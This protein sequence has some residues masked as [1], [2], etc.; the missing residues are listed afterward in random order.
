MARKRGGGSGHGGQRSNSNKD[1]TSSFQDV[2]MSSSIASTGNNF[3]SVHKRGPSKIVR[4]MQ[5]PA[6][7]IEMQDL[8]SASALRTMLFY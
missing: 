1:S 7:D 3:S 2:K 4:A 5:Q 8:S 6:E